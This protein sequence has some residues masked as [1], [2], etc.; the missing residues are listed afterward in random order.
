[1]D[2]PSDSWLP[3]VPVAPPSDLSDFVGAESL[4]A[5]TFN[6]DNA[7][8][9]DSGVAS[10]IADQEPALS[11]Y[12]YP[13]SDD[14]E[15]L[16]FVRD[17]LRRK[18]AQLLKDKEHTQL[19]LH[20]L[21]L[22]EE[23]D[24]ITLENLSARKRLSSHHGTPYAT[25]R[26]PKGDIKVLPDQQDNQKELNQPGDESPQPTRKVSSHE[27]SDDPNP[28]SNA[29]ESSTFEFTPEVSWYFF[30]SGLQSII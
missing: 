9:M 10:H 29:G 23:I 4:D 5:L 17:S 25:Y 14:L 28:P 27:G 7:T 30:C 8:E 21:R 26:P 22:R 13:L 16:K 18:K 1:M 2:P 12:D 15:E 3:H 24:L 6:S 19:V 20:I 11:A